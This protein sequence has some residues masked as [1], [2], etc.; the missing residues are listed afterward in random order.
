MS[1]GQEQGLVA[2]NGPERR[3]TVDERLNA[4]ETSMGELKDDI[5]QVVTILSHSKWAFRVIAA[6]G[7]CAVGCVTF[8]Y[9]LVGL[10]Q[11]IQH[12]GVTPPGP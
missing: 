7:V 3:A 5:K 6:L 8:A 9:Y 2:Y 12:P 4:L 11:E 1:A 10:L